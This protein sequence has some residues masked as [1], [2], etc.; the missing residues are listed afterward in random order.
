MNQPLHSD[1]GSQE[2]DSSSLG[3]EL[4][5][6]REAAG[7]SVAEAARRLRVPHHVVSGLEADDHAQLGAPIFVRGHAQAYARLVGVP[8]G[9][10]DRLGRHEAPPPLVTMAPSTRMQ[11]MLDQAGRR[12]V[13]VVLTAVLVVPAFYIATQGP[14]APARV[15]LDAPVGTPANPGT[16]LDL[17]VPR[18]PT[19]VMD[20]APA[21]STVIA[22][23][24]PF[25]S[26][27]ANERAEPDEA[28]VAVASQADDFVLR[29]RGESWVEVFGHDGSRIHQA[30]MREGEVLRFAAGQV[31]RVT[32]GNAGVVDVVSG[33]EVLSTEPFSRANVA[34]F[35]VSSDGRLATLGG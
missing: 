4:R 34:R 30:L 2:A 13:Y 5:D 14:E 12:A 6:A 15:S 10:V 32:L 17:R 20:A 24:A 1:P 25:R 28:E 29:F 21:P 22:S 23:I 7:L 3:Q 33:G 11:R 35:T 19:P 26:G 16:E 27:A 31:D 8:A 18:T 9:R